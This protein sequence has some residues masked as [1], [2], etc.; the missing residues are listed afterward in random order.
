MW[1]APHSVPLSFLFRLGHTGIFCLEPQKRRSRT[2]ASLLW[3]C[4]LERR[5]TLLLKAIMSC[6]VEVPSACR[7]AL[8]LMFSLFALL[9]SCLCCALS[10]T[11]SSWRGRWRRGRWPCRRP[12]WRP[13]GWTQ[14][15]LLLSPRSVAFLLHLN[16]VWPTHLLSFPCVVLQV[17][18]STDIV[19]VTIL[20]VLLM[21]WRQMRNLQTLS[22]SKWWRRKLKIGHRAPRVLTMGEC[23]QD[24][25]GNLSVKRSAF[26]N[27]YTVC[28]VLVS[29]RKASLAGTAGAGAALA[30]EH[31]RGPDHALQ[32]DS[33]YHSH[34]P[35]IL[36]T[37][38]VVML[39]INK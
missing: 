35:V 14:M 9:T 27:I 1:H 30:P 8:A 37:Q 21:W 23:I 18:W 34:G 22:C 10:Q 26:R 5:Y 24:I 12:S 7:H 25:R 39:I 6:S 32:D 20:Q 16:Q 19:F 36:P 29:G 3:R 17:C 31:A 38:T 33:E 2:S 28:S 11:T 13:R 4:T 15:E